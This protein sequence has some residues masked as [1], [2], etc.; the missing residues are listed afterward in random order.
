MSA[1][2]GGPPRSARDPGSLAGLLADLAAADAN[3]LEVEHLR[4][5]ASLSVDEVEIALEL[6]TKSADHC[7][8]V[9]GA[10]R[11]CGYRVVAG[12]SWPI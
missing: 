7:A 4:T 5:N 11:S 1:A 10:L 6:E 3:V 9:L 8:E 2:P 12:D